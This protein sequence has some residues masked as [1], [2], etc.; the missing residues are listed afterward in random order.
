MNIYLAHPAFTEKQKEFKSKF[1][2]AFNALMKETKVHDTHGGS[3]CTL[4]RHVQILDPFDYSPRIE[5][6][7]EAIRQMSKIVLVTNIELMNKSD[8]IIAVIDDRDQGVI[9][10]MGYAHASGIPTITISNEQHDINIM[11]SSSVDGHFMN[12]NSDPKSMQNLCLS[13]VAL[14]KSGYIV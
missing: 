5:G 14:I 11:L 7:R 1:L 3:E 10:E 6:D 12:I 4:D 2:N 8:L 13:L 9:W